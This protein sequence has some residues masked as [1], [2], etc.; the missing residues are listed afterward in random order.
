[1]KKYRG[2][3]R[4]KPKVIHTWVY[5]YSYN[6]KC[7]IIKINGKYHTTINVMHINTHKLLYIFSKIIR[8]TNF[9]ERKVTHEEILI[10]L[11]NISQTHDIFHN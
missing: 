2:M 1:M 8:W 7:V 3:R 4:I 5:S 10:K 11:I 9:L 6:N